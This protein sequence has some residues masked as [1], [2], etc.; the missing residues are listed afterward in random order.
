MTTR[1]Q[2]LFLCFMLIAIGLFALWWWNQG[3][4]STDDAF[5]ERDVIYLKPRISGRLESLSV[6]SYQQVHAGEVLATIDPSPFRVAVTAAEANLQRAQASV[7]TAEAELTAFLADDKARLTNAQ[8]QVAVAEANVSLQR[9][10][11]DTLSARLDQARRDVDRYQSLASRQQVSRRTLEDSQTQLDTLSSEQVATR[12]GVTVAEQEL[13]STRA[14]VEVAQANSQRRQ[15]LEANV[16]QAQAGVSQAEAELEQARLQLSWTRITAP[17]DGWVSEIQAKTGSMVSP[18]TT[19]SILVAG[20]PWIKANF[21]ETQLDGMKVG[22]TVTIEVDA[23]PGRE[24]KGHV[25]AFQPGTGARFALL[26]PENAT[27]N[28]VKVVQRIPVRINLDDI[29]EDVDLWPGL[30]VLPTVELGSAGN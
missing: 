15:V 18:T 28:F 3:E 27:G 17:V 14:A 12:A 2:R 23:Y 19:L 24:L 29:P 4:E 20:T 9:R 13:A 8:A 21:K 22:D 1:L 6:D 10:Q 11:L 16:S 26:P 5:V 30:S 7:A 25:A